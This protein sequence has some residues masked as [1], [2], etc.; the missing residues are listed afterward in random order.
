MVAGGENLRKVFMLDKSPVDVPPVFVVGE[1]ASLS[2]TLIVL[3]GTSASIPLTIE[4]VGRNA[5]VNLS[6]LYLS[7]GEDEM[8][9]DIILQ[10]RTEDGRSTQLFNGIIGE[11][12]CCGF[13]G[14]IIIAPDA[15]RVAAFQE[16]HN[17]LLSDNARVNAKP[18]LE[19]YA[20]DVKCS[21]GATVGK[22]NEE[23]QYYMRSRGIPESEARVLQMISFIAPIINALPESFELTSSQGTGIFSRE[24]LLGKV[25][26]AVRDLEKIK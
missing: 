23:E 20:D 14:K 9:I 16:N 10:H 19:I 24:E 1:N 26:G 2:L 4:V 17:I 12:A 15:Q 18:R 8:S 13:F 5:E 25:E 11:S 21:H 22:L 3:P 7:S 6:G